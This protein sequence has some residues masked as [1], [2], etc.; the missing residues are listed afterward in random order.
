MS[1]ID[2]EQDKLIYGTKVVFEQAA[3]YL[4]VIQVSS[5]GKKYKTVVNQT[6]Q[7]STSITR[8]DLF[9]SKGRYVRIVYNGLPNDVRAGHYSFEIY[10]E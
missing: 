9:E 4:Y 10:G 8:E 1:E 7:T 2:L 3:N 6:G 5:D